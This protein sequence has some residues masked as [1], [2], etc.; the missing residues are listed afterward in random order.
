MWN[1][2]ESLRERVEWGLA[3]FWRNTKQFNLEIQG[4]YFNSPVSCVTSCRPDCRVTCS[5]WLVRPHARWNSGGKCRETPDRIDL[6]SVRIN[7]IALLKYVDCQMGRCFNGWTIWV[8]GCTGGNWNRTKCDESLAL[9]WLFSHKRWDLWVFIIR[10]LW[11][12]CMN[13]MQPVDVGDT[14]CLYPI[15]MTTV[16]SRLVRKN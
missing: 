16:V 13:R 8:D 11:P 10:L 3:P 2:I 4:H 5:R 6:D 9:S 1:T 15:I 14:S 12:R 7:R